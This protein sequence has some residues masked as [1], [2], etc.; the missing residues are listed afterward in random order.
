MERPNS[1]LPFLAGPLA[2]GALR[3]D[4]PL[5]LPRHLSTSAHVTLERRQDGITH[6]TVRRA[7]DDEEDPA[8]TVKCKLDTKNEWILMIG[9]TVS[10]KS[11]A[12]RVEAGMMKVARIVADEIPRKHPDRVYVDHANG[13]STDDT[14]ANLHWV[15]PAF[16]AYNFL[17]VAGASNFFGVYKRDSNMFRVKAHQRLQGT[18]P[19]AETAALVFNLIVR[20][21]FGDQLDKTPRLLNSIDNEASRVSKVL[22][23]RDGAMIF[24]VDGFHLVIYNLKV[25]SKHNTLEEA[26]KPAKTLVAT[27][28]AEQARKEQGWAARINRLRITHRENGVAYIPF[29]G[30]KVLLDD[31]SWRKVTVRDAKLVPFF[32]KRPWICFDEVNTDL[33]RWLTDA[34]PTDVVDHKNGN[35][36]DDRLNNLRITDLSSNTQNCRRG[37]QYK[38]VTFRRNLWTVRIKPNNGDRFAQTSFSATELSA[39]LELYDLAALD[40]Y[41]AGSFINNSLKRGEY[42]TLLKTDKATQLRVKTF[43]EKKKEPTSYYKGVSIA[44]SSRMRL[45]TEVKGGYISEDTGE[46]VEMTFK[47]SIGSS[48]KGA[49]VKVAVSYDLWRL[50]LQGSDMTVN[51]EWMRPW[52]LYQLPILSKGTSDNLI[53]RA[54]GLLG[55]K[56]FADAEKGLFDETVSRPSSSSVPS[57][58]ASSSSS[59]SSSGSRKRKSPE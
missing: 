10:F 21:E 52:Y 19:S 46:R 17:K 56:A 40:Q 15:T 1:P 4:L 33:A 38:G 34:R 44:P 24:K 49:A 13:D 5:K 16:N 58:A 7:I 11:G 54:Y 31:E 12:H 37:F 26:K 39:A 53:K 47:K 36:L 59:P 32:G 18:Y 35:P 3:G 43:L 2:S 30:T 55:G 22:S 6:Y 14:V 50:K 28:E 20:L 23:Q 9:V 45:R 48:Q 29:L 51:F 27:L 42:L 41:G 25:R 57:S 8:T